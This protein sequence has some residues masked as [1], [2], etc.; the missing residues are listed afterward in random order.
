MIGYVSF[1]YSFWT[2]KRTII[3]YSNSTKEMSQM[4]IEETTNRSG[5]TYD[6]GGSTLGTT[7]QLAPVSEI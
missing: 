4:Q 2:N 3:I 7:Q 1:F 6:S 5:L